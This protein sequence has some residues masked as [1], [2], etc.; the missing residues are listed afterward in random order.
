MKKIIM[1]AVIILSLT[2]CEVRN[3]SVAAHETAPPEIPQENSQAEI[4]QQ[5]CGVPLLY[6]EA[7]PQAAANTL[8]LTIPEGYTLVRIGMMLEEMGVCTAE[9]FIQAAQTGDFSEFPLIAAQI[10]NSNRFLALEGY[11]FPGTYEIYADELPDSIIRRM[12]SKTERMIDDAL[13]EIIAESDFTVDEILII[14]SIIQKESLGDDDFKPLV[15]SVIHS[16]LSIGM[17]L[18]MCYTAFYVRDYIDPL[19]ENEG[20]RFGA[21]YNTYICPALPAGAICNPGLSAIHA[22]LF[23]AETQYFFYIWDRDNNFHFA[24]T[25]E[26]HVA[27]VQRYLH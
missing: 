13:R 25:W 10:P 17:M 22:A 7:S 11:L 6:E 20:H 16:R 15:S 3:E 23:P 14:A 5:E 24:A 19:F 26:E 9:E 2:G 1:I 12:L 27:N 18:Q 4:P 21:Y 8:T